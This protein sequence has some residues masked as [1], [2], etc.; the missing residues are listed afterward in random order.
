MEIKIKNINFIYSFPFQFLGW[1]SEAESLCENVEQEIERNPL[2]HKV[3][4]S[5]SRF[6]ICLYECMC[7]SF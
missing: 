3:C 7:V 1:L 6:Y 2:V 5:F 4:V